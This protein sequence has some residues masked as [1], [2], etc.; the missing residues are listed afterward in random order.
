MVSGLERNF[1]PP[2]YSLSC[3]EV[4]SRATSAGIRAEN[5]LAMFRFVEPEPHDNL[6]CPSWVVDFA[7]LACKD[8]LYRRRGW[9][10]TNAHVHL[11]GLRQYNLQDIISRN[12]D[13]LQFVLPTVPLGSVH[14]ALPL[15]VTHGT[16]PSSKEV[17]TAAVMLCLL[18]QLCSF[19]PSPYFS[20][21]AED[22]EP[23]IWNVEDSVTSANLCNLFKQYAASVGMPYPDIIRSA[24]NMGRARD[25]TREVSS[26]LDDV[27]FDGEI[28][29]I[30]VTP[31]SH[32]AAE[33][34]AKS[35]SDTAYWPAPLQHVLL[36]LAWSCARQGDELFIV[37]NDDFLLVAMPTRILGQYLFRGFAYI[38][39]ITQNEP[40]AMRDLDWAPFFQNITLC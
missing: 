29:L 39:S 1:V 31:I 19:V 15:T 24:A 3:A 20:R 32:R 13:P 37:P 36:R 38:G 40:E 33:T 8:G 28:H 12:N 22:L 10:R 35:R 2:D 25:T 16:V 26:M 14:T 18:D 21:S 30:F 11:F 7:G 34:L 17:K 6:N 9:D 4:C 27:L 5:D 23:A